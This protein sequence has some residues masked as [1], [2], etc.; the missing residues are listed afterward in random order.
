MAA[1]FGK[2]LIIELGTSLGIST[3]YM[4]ASCRDTLVKTIEGS[5]AI[6]DIATT[7]FYWMLIFRIL[8]CYQGSFDDVIP[9]LA[10]AGVNQD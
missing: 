8:M 7:E 1:E 9:D 4:A 5:G 6:A 2:P 3:M 10:L